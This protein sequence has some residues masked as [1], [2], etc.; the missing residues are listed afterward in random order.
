MIRVGNYIII[1]SLIILYSPGYDLVIDLEPTHDYLS[2]C[3]FAYSSETAQP[4]DFPFSL[5]QSTRPDLV[6][7]LGCVSMTFDLHPQIALKAIPCSLAP[8]SEQLLTIRIMP[9]A[10]WRTT[11]NY[12]NN[13]L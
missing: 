13:V 8:S 5:Q 3:L 12:K 9:G 6:I 11:T 2:A 1:C 7:R 10:I 4:I